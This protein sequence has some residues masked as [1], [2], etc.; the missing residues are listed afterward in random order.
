MPYSPP[1]YSQN[2][3]AAVG[4][5]SVIDIGDV[6]VGDIPAVI[7]ITIT[8]TATVLVQGSHDGINFATFTTLT[9]DDALDLITGIRFWRTRVS[10]W[11]NGTIT[12]SVGYVPRQ[13]GG[14]Q[15]RLYSTTS[16]TPGLP[17]S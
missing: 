1:V 11:T 3:V 9:A 13:G 7:I 6:N 2:G 14:V 16:N 8:G 10:A 12:S 15:P 5:G 4:N 17:G